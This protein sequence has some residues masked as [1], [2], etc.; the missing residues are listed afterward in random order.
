MVSTPTLSE[1]PQA[2]VIRSLRQWIEE[3]TYDGGQPLPSEQRLSEQLGVS[4]GTVRRA[5]AIL[6]DEGVVAQRN[7]RT[8]MVPTQSNGGI[9]VSERGGLMHHVIAVL[10]DSSETPQHKQGGWLEYVTAGALSAIQEAGWHGLSLHP[11][12]LQ[13][14]EVSRILA[15][16]PAGVVVTDLPLNLMG[17][18]LKGLHKAGTSVVFYGDLPDYA[19]FDRVTSD[20]EA[21]AYAVTRF[22]IEKGRRRILQT[23]TE[24]AT[25]YWYVGRRAGY[26]RAMREANLEILPMLTTPELRA[27]NSGEFEKNARHL[28]G[29]L[30]EHL[31]SENRVDAIMASTDADV[32]GLAAACRVFGQIPNQDVWIAGYDNYWAEWPTRQFEETAPIVTVDKSNAEI[33]AALV[34]LALARIEGHLPAQPQRRVVAPRL[35]EV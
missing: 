4:R 3:G 14:A 35:V 23:A 25:G 6:D 11:A 17:T 30:V 12:R 5:L 9:G 31:T 15:D 33:G 1:R 34:E 24:P 20:H 26:E 28:A 27:Q 8:R 10:T 16:P 21:G 19:D 22:L 13:G 32:Y 2:R 7:G 29:Y 18:L